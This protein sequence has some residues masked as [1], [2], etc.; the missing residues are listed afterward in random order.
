MNNIPDLTQLTTKI[1]EFIEEANKRRLSDKTNTT[2]DILPYDQYYILTV[3]NWDD[4]IGLNNFK[5]NDW[6]Y[7]TVIYMKGELPFI[8]YMEKVP[9]IIYPSDI[10]E[11]F[12][13]SPKGN[14]LD[15]KTN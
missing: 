6:T 2:H 7:M 15:E 8:N 12:C 1:L 11:L 5:D 10:A 3:P 13:R 9:R 4:W 14:I